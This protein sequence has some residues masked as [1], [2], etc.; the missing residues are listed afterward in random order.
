MAAPRV[1]RK[2]TAPRSFHAPTQPAVTPLDDGRRLRSGS[3]GHGLD[4]CAVHPVRDRMREIDDDLLEAAAE[5]RLVLASRARRRYIQYEPVR[6]LLGV[7][8]V[9]GT[10]SCDP[11]APAGLSTRRPSA[12]PVVD[13][14]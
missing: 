6:P 1:V 8:W 11:D 7:R 9:L 10:T 2:S 5:P 13:R 14:S 12:L 4:D 3:P